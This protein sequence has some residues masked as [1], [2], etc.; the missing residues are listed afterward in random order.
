V[1]HPILDRLG[2]SDPEARRRACAEA[3]DDPSAVLLAD[4]LG[5]VLGDPVPEVAR[6]AS[7]ALAAL[8]R[9]HDVAEVV[10]QALRSGDPPRRLRAALI[11]AQLA[12]PGPRLLPALAEGLGS[13]DGASRWAAARLLVETGRLHGEVQPLLLGLARAHPDPVVRRMALHCL[14]ELAPDEPA[15]AAALLEA[16]RDPEIRARR[17]AYAAL[18]ALLDPAPEAMERLGEALQGEPDGACRRIA[19]VALGKLGGA[20]GARVPPAV[21]EALRCAARDPA[22]PDLRRGASRALARIERRTGARG[23]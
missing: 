16:T 9:N 23:D 10:R 12:P 6:A 17:A 15:V 7:E 2:S 4:A 14:R 1:S 18:A 13:P 11:A 8:G 3:V 5:E 21:L 19:S 22:D 20:D